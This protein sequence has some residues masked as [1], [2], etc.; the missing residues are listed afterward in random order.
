M[1]P[2]LCAVLAQRSTSAADCLAVAPPSP[3]EYLIWNPI[4]AARISTP[5]Q[6]A[7]L[8]DTVQQL[9]PR[10][11]G[12]SLKCLGVG[13]SEGAACPTL[14][15]LLAPLRFL[16]PILLLMP[17]TLP[18]KPWIL[19]GRCF[20]QEDLCCSGRR[21]TSNPVSL[22]SAKRALTCTFC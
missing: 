6:K 7:L 17:Q 4:D 9:T 21:R 8:A 20:M 18:G 13:F 2:L 22:V 10:C 19:K 5:C 3:R 16:A 1:L 14:S 15:R 12:W 11:S